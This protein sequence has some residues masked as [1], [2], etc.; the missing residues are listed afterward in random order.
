MFLENN[1]YYR[2][3]T[4]GRPEEVGVSWERLDGLLKNVAVGTNV[5]VGTDS[6]DNIFIREGKINLNN[7]F[8]KYSTKERNSYVSWPPFLKE[9]FT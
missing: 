3:D 6:E 9:S 4:Y 8:V 5:V 7:S 2:I 1:I